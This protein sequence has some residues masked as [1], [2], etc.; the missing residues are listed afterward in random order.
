MLRAMQVPARLRAIIAVALTPAFAVVG[1]AHGWLLSP[2]QAAL[3]VLF[4]TPAV[5]FLAWLALGGAR[6]PHGPPDG[7]AAGRWSA[8]SR[9]FHWVMALCILG[10]SALFYWMSNLD[11]ANDEAASRA[12][13][14]QWLVVHKSLGLVVLFLVLLRA[15]WNLAVQRPPLPVDMTR[16]QRAVALAVHRA[17][18]ALMLATPVFGWAASMTFGAGT[19]FFGLFDMP[20]LL[21]KDEALVKFFHPGHKYLAW[22]LLALVGLHVAAALWHHLVRR[23]A[24]L[25]RMLPGR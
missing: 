5:A 18:Y 6:D 14:R 15:A 2:K 7:T 23:D 16:R 1:F 12:T 13:F 22:T 10:A 25:W 24:T 4:A 17:I 3:I 20:L 8:P 9:M 19:S 11:F 21:S